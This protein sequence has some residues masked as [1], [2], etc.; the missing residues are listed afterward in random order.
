MVHAKR[1]ALRRVPLFAGL[2]ESEVR[3][4]AS[5]AVERPY[6]PGEVLGGEG[7]PCRGIFLLGKGRVRIFKSAPNGREIMLGMESA[8]C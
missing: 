8:P 2:S 3:A 5:R 4:L 6:P 1:D 7:G